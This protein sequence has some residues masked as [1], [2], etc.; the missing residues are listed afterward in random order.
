MSSYFLHS[1]NKI[2]YIN[3]INL[4][5]ILMF[6]ILKHTYSIKQLLNNENIKRI[7]DTIH[8]GRDWTRTNDLYDVNVVLYQLSYSTIYLTLDSTKY[9]FNGQI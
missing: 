8:G 7:I 2:V 9:Y 4:K 6:Y 5:K 1:I 3:I